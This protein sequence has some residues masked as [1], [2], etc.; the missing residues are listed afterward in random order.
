[1]SRFV[2]T[3]IDDIIDELYK[4]IANDFPNV[5]IHDNSI[6][7]R[8]VI[9]E[10]LPSEP[11]KSSEDDEDREESKAIEIE[12]YIS[13]SIENYY[14]SEARPF[15]RH[16][17]ALQV[18]CHYNNEHIAITDQ[19]SLLKRFTNPYRRARKLID[20]ARELRD[21]INYYQLDKHLSKILD[22]RIDNAILGDEACP[23][24]KKLSDRQTRLIVKKQLKNILPEVEKSLELK[25]QK[26]K[27]GFL[28]RKK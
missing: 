19:I 18:S 21:E 28:L 6:T 14:D 20:F 5:S 2:D 9:T 4:K 17:T 26:S 24:K 1:M 12:H 27:K 11:S 16:S 3:A 25:R 7:W 22:D 10:D 13:L 23:K 15:L 8:K